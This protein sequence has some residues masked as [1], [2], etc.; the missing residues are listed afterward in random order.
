MAKRKLLKETT[1]EKHESE[2][3]CDIDNLLASLTAAEVEEL[4]NELT[5]INPDPTVPVGLR[6]RNQ[7]EKQPSIK[8]N[9]VAMLDF[10]ERETKKLI[11][12]E[13][14]FEGEPK[15]DRGKRGNLMKMGKSCESFFSVSCDQDDWSFESQSHDS[16][17]NKEDKPDIKELKDVD[18]GEG[19]IEEISGKKNLAVDEYINEVVE[20]N[21]QSQMGKERKEAC[22]KKGKSNC[23]TFD[24][25]SKFQSKNYIKDEKDKKEECRKKTDK[26]KELISKLQGQREKEET[27]KE[28]KGK[29]QKLMDS[30]IRGIFFKE[31]DRESDMR[32]ATMKY[33]RESEKDSERESIKS[34][35]QNRLQ[36]ETEKNRDKTTEKIT[37]KPCKPSHLEVK[38]SKSKGPANE[39]VME[40]GEENVSSIFD[41][42]LERVRN[43][44]PLL[45][46]LN[47]NN[48]DVIKTETL[49]QF[50]EALLDN[51]HVKSFA[52]ANTRADDHVAYAV[53]NTLRSNTC[54][55]S[56]NLDS[57][58]LTGKGIL[59][60]IH[61]IENNTILTELRFHNQRHICGGKTEMEM[62]KTL[63]DNTTLLKLG[64]HFELAGPRMTITNILSRN[65]DQQRQRR[66]QEKTQANQNQRTLS[67]QKNQSSLHAETFVKTTNKLPAD[68]ELTNK[69]KTT[70]PLAKEKANTLPNLFTVDS[71]L[72]PSLKGCPKAGSGQPGPVGLSP[73]PSRGL[74]GS[75]LRKSF[76]AVS[77]R[78][79]NGQTSHHEG[80]RNSRDQL[81]ASICNST[82]K[83][84]K[85][86]DVPKLL[87]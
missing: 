10:C 11:E 18:K 26:T 15:S 51:R 68:K 83:V 56:I 86:V 52:L 58:N 78:K 8:Y 24:I 49:I 57:N 76:T 38:S 66:M 42:L 6:Q 29:P 7:T 20:K 12:R 54:L 19:I 32:E 81:L 13:L 61:A 45:T 44:D 37:R 62:T 80:R 53:A 39:E 75:F 14:S 84:L 5:D 65:L 33:Q 70:M 40:E 28:R 3:D 2:E 60:L 36:R 17:K 27:G 31:K 48:S 73:P 46:D 63:K 79:Q 34:V 4:E 72:K 23:K 64:Y 69:K 85:K 55:T 43:D 71:S 67:S 30:K 87:R 82:L 50:A 22:S 47:V 25:I 35:K 16:S 21:R 9:R 41:K 59:A 74:D 77:Q 1:L